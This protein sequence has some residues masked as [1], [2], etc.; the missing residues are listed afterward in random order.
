LVD[1]RGSI[2]AEARGSR[3]GGGVV[4]GP[5]LGFCSVWRGVGGGNG[6]MGG[7]GSGAGVYTGALTGLGLGSFGR[8]GLV[9]EQNWVGEVRLVI[10]R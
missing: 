10:S 2:P 5:G 7:L 1:Y 9:G 8:L 3:A 4:C 6:A